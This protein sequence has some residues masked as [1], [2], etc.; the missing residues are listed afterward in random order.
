MEGNILVTGATG[1]IGSEL[2]PL[3]RSRYGKERVIAMGHHKKPSD[4]IA[5]SGPFIKGDVTDMSGIGAALKENDITQVYHLAALLSAV[6]EKDPQLAWE[7]NMRGLTN[8]LELS[9]QHP[10]R[11]FWP[12][13]IAVFGTG[14]PRDATPQETVLL[15]TT[16]YG[17]TKVAG[18]LLC[19]YHHRKYGTDVRSVRYPGIISS[20]TPPGGG[21]TDYAVAVFYEAVLRGKYQCFVRPDTVLPMMYMPDSLAAA[22]SIMEADVADIKRRD[23]YNL[24]SLSFSAEQLTDAIRIHIPELEVSYHP[25][26]RQSIADS[27]PRSLDD[28]CARKDW[29]WEPEW[30]L[31]AM[32]KDMLAKLQARH[33][34]GRLQT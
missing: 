27:W 19:S 32:V 8:M 7:L 21:T 10:I 34:E 17:V 25:D 22:V 31:P 24:N 4:E 33:A 2:I 9:R 12:S 29:G 16:M 14:Y 28:S 20:E 6:G 11:I 15:P 18:E 26:F 30:D 23:G 13:S 1:Q 5:S 3:L